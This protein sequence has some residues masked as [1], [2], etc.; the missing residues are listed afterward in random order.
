MS[1]S[2]SWNLISQG[3]VVAYTSCNVRLLPNFARNNIMY[4]VLNEMNRVTHYL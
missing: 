2:K 3:L 1:S 4:L